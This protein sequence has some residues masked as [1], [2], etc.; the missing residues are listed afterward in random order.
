MQFMNTL[1]INNFTLHGAREE[2]TNQADFYLYAYA[3]IMEI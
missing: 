2:V 1:L 3:T